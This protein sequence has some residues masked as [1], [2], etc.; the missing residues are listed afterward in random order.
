MNNFIIVENYAI[1]MDNDEYLAL[2]QTGNT[3]LEG[4]TRKD[5]DAA[6]IYSLSD[7]KEI[8]RA[9]LNETKVQGIFNVFTFGRKPVAYVKIKKR[10]EILSE[11]PI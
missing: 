9:I 3:L 1:K 5:L 11:K 8:V 4:F 7:A 6:D 10:I 2:D